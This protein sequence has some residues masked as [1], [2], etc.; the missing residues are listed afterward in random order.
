M[1]L[2]YETDSKL[3]ALAPVLDEHAEWFCRATKHIFF[4][5][6]FKGKEG[7]DVPGSF[8]LWLNAAEGYDFIDKV[9]LDD[10]KKLFAELHMVAKGLCDK[11]ALALESVTLR[12][13]EDFTNLYE[14][15]LFK[16]RRLEQDCALVDSG[17]D[18]ET[19]LR[20]RNAME[21]DI[22]RELERRARQGNPFTLALARID[23]YP[24]L[25]ARTE[26]DRQAHEKVMRQLGSLIKRCIRSFD[27][28]YRSSEGEFIM[29]LKHSKASGGTAAVNRLRNYLSEDNIVVSVDGDKTPL[30]MS[31]CVAEPVP[32]DTLEELL[33]NMRRDLERWK[34][35]GDMA[36]EYKE[37]SPLARYI[38]EKE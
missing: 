15:F 3:K 37:L 19:G 20:S 21:I 26:A 23:N 7:L 36:M 13:Y 31:Y 8:Q 14:S 29:C 34:E 16:L 33:A 22:A 5:D 2:D 25:N 18:L 32:G 12:E 11:T 28:G 6:A 4:P 1:T 9:T 10:L 38:G 27:D 17:L 30:T 35:G 24:D